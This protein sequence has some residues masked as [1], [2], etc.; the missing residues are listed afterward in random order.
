MNPLLA[1]GVRLVRAGGALRLVSVVA[2]CALAVTL[3]VTAWGLPDAIYPVADGQPVDPRRGPLVSLLV[4]AVVPVLALVLIVGRL[5][6]EVRDRRLASLRLLGVPRRQVALVAAVENL[7]PALVGAALG[8]LGSLVLAAALDVLLADALDAPVTAS[9]ARILAVVAGV[10]GVS[11]ALALA[12]VRRLGSPRTGHTAAAARR[13]SWWR[14]APLV[15]TVVAFAVLHTVPADRLR[16]WTAPIF[17]VAVVGGALAVVLVAPLVSYAAA[18]GL[19]G[20][21]RTDLLLA[22]RGIQ[23]QAAPIGRRVMALGLAVFAVVGGAGFL[24]IAEGAT[25]L[26]AAIHEMEVGPQQIHVSLDRADPARFSAELAAVPGVRAVVPTYSLGPA[27]CSGPDVSPCAQVFV[28][29][30]ESLSALVVVTGCRDGEPAWIDTDATGWEDTIPAVT[31][32]GS[33]DVA[34]PDGVPHT[35]RLTGAIT[36]DVPATTQ[37]WVWPGQ[38]HVFIPV[39]LARAWGH[40]PVGLV[41]VADAGARVGARVDELSAAAGEWSDTS[42]RYDYESVVATRVAA[43]T[44]MAVSVGVALLAYGLAAVDRAREQRR[45]RA[46]LVALGVPAGLL[47]RVE[48]VQNL[49]PLLTTIALATG[50]GLATTGALASTDDQPFSLDPALL[51]RLLGLVTAGAVLISCATVPF[52]RSRMEASDLRDD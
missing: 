8:I 2:G 38:Q 37:R 28:G 20:S 32:V 52:T 15:P 10:V 42:A 26:R 4:I 44:L 7:V 43:W 3:L 18:G 24:S 45:P 19:V 47:R 5:S 31:P 41:V 48:G 40:E 22:G 16:G 1:L 35:V 34:G 33:L 21:R 11:V 25:H 14:L 36:Q 50:L 51:A 13:P 27:A 17:L 30:C 12:P 23:T 6:S 29:T 49:V 39:D 46:R 9:V